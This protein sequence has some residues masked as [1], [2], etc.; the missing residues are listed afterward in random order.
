M[1]LRT[2]LPIQL[3][4]IPPTAPATIT[5][6]LSSMS[7][8]LIYSG[9]GTAPIQSPSAST[10]STKETLDAERR[11]SLNKQASQQQPGSNGEGDH[12]LASLP[13]S[14]RFTSQ[15]PP[16][17]LFPTPA[18]SHKTP[19]DSITPRQVRGGLF[20]W[21][22]P[23]TQTD[24]ELLAVS[25]AALRDLNI[26]PGEATTEGFRQWAA[27]NVLLGWDE[28][29]LTGG[30]PWAQ[31][32]GGFQFGQWAGQLG[33]GRAISLFETTSPT[34]RD[35]WAGGAHETKYEVQLKGA[36]MTPYSR[37]ADGKAVLRSSI[38]EFVVSEALHALGIP[39]TRALALSLLPHSRVR[40]ET[41]EPGAIV[42]RF[43]QSWVRLGN[44]DILR[45]RGDRDSIRKLA[46]Y[47]AEEV[48][49]GW[50]RLPSRL[51]SPDKPADAP[52]LERP[53]RGV[54][55]KD[56]VQGPADAAENRFA[57]MYREAV[58]RN[59]LTVA[60]WQAYG[61]M[62][63]VLNTDNTSIY[64]L[65]IDFG[66][67]AFMDNFDPAYTPNHDDHMLRYSYRNQ[68]TIIWWNLVRFGEA[69]GELL[70]AGDTVDS[71]KFVV[72]GVSEGAEADE[73]VARAEKLIEQ[74]GEE[75]KAV[76]L[77]EYK[78]LMTARLGL[79]RFQESDFQ[80]LFS[81]LLDAM[82]ALE[83]DFHHTFRR[84]S[85][86]RVADLDTEDLRRETAGVF[87]HKEGIS[88]TGVTEAE[89]RQRVAA[90]LEKWRARVVEDWGVEGEDG[91]R[92]VDSAKE[93]E[94]MSAMKKVNPSFIPRSFILDEIIQRAE[95]GGERDV[96]RRVMQMALHPFEEQ[97]DG[98][99][100]EGTVYKGEREEEVRWTGDVPRFQRA[101]QC[102]C[103]S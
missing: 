44:F 19:R 95:K 92:V 71:D 79:R 32:Y 17:P 21:V 62:N 15:L 40:R 23:E 59:A 54:V 58:R 68:P 72:D 34:A 31:L 57:R 89:A 1:P 51:S 67:F 2:I 70:G 55:G 61:F 75:Y 27:G 101:M 82:E 10:A 35:P 102:S 85:Y 22:R 41:V 20:T 6:R 47:V 90:W 38:R 9:N 99:D 94:R 88:A 29:R 65:S 73:L 60:K 50:D 98:N 42:V 83:L 66:P 13:K 39:T 78:R 8:Q 26:K 97:W 36:G 74:A 63:G 33:D 43:A 24:P 37:F 69:V 56:E 5:R 81:G 96:L 3:R 48:L 4:R 91:K 14:W 77:A 87:F 11:E 46:T 52:E 80:E 30:Y 18:D 93:E 25:P 28:E 49:G 7:E 86:V 76:F 53:P 100:F 84:L 16:D 45:A 12:T 64:G 103:S